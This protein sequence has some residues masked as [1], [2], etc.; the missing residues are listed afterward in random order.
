MRVNGRV[1]FSD[2]ETP[3]PPGAFDVVFGDYDNVWTTSTREDGEF[4]L[5]LLIPSVP[6]GKLDLRLE[7]G[8][9][10]GLAMDE[11]QQTPRVR[12]TVDNSRPT[13]AAISLDEVSANS[14][15]SIGSCGNL[16]VMLETFDDHGFDLNEPTVLHYRVRAG[17]AEI[18][19]G[20]V[21]LPDTTPF[22]DQFFWTGYLDLTDAGATTLLP[23]YTVDVWVSGSDSSGNPFDTIGNSLIEPIASWPLALLGPSIDLDNEANSFSWD[24]PS[25]VAEQAVNLEFEVLNTGGK[26]DV[27][28]VLQRSVEGGFWQNTARV[29]LVAGAGGTLTGSLPTVANAAVGESI[30]FRL[31]V[32]VDEVEMDRK[33]MDPV[34]IK[35]QTVRDGE[36]LAQQAQ[37]G[38]FSIVLYIIALLS[39]SMAMWLLVVNRRIDKL[40]DEPSEDQTEEV[41]E[42]MNLSKSIPAIDSSVPPPSGLIL[43]AQPEA[44]PPKPVAPSPQPAAP[45]AAAGAR[46]PPPLPP[47]GL[48][49]GWTQEQWNHF[50]WQYVEALKK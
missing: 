44:A 23:S 30:E 20:S 1:L 3:A 27:A 39:L 31:L 34:L 8:D 4:S 42:E 41:L 13:I 14:E 43:P 7:L 11:T 26:G 16:L 21:P 9:L 46:A 28:F 45:V 25:P 29:D 18:S 33:S 37:E 35:E 40:S 38:T 15:L 12:L 49:A 17:E 5:D 32:L 2:S 19:R 48:P 50:G 22:G 6:S 47:T 36:A 24:D 10:P